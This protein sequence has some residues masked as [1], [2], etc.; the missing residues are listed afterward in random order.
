MKLLHADVFEL[1]FLSVLAVSG[2]A[3]F[4]MLTVAGRYMV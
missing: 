4:A 2:I 3:A 1:L